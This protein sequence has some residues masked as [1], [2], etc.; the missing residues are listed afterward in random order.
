MKTLK[1][2]EEKQA[3]VKQV[4]QQVQSLGLDP[5]HPS[6]KQLYVLLRQFINDDIPS[7]GKLSLPEF[8]RVLVYHLPQSQGKP[9][10]VQL[11]F[12]GSSEKKAT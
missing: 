5:S 9:I 3:E 12:V 7:S 6:I 8:D 10:S 1:S 2:K 11:K 4:I